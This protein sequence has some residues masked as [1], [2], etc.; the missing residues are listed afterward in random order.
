VDAGDALHGAAVTQGQALAVDVLE[1]P[2]FEVPYSA[3][4]MSSSA[5]SA[6]GIDGLHRYSS[7]SLL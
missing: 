5:G 6:H 7:P 1:L 2:M 3:I 4:G